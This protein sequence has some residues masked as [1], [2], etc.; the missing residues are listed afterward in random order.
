MAPEDPD[1]SD[2]SCADDDGDGIPNEDD[3]APED[4]DCSDWDCADDDDDGVLNGEDAAPENPDCS[5]DSCSEENDCYCDAEC[6]EDSC[7]DEGYDN[8]FEGEEGEGG[9]PCLDY[10]ECGDDPY[11]EYY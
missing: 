8:P 4:P 6:W 9:D 2:D 11:H 10:G 3:Y 1:C 5:D 7:E